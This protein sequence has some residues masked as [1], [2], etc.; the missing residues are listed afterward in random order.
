MIMV[1]VMTSMVVI[2]RVNLAII[3]M[4]MVI[5]RTIY[6]IVILIQLDGRILW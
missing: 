2:I 3:V 5:S 6:N 4:A 1:I